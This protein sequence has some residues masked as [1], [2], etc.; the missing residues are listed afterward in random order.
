ML[1]QQ[2]SLAH[3]GS[4]GEAGH[5][6][7]LAVRAQAL[8]QVH[9]LVVAPRGGGNAPQITRLALRPGLLS[10]SHETLHKAVRLAMACSSR[11]QGLCSGCF[12]CSLQHIRNETR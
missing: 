10:L 4:N 12:V 6:A 8:V 1:H 11:R 3:R 2:Q 5:R 9:T 7:V